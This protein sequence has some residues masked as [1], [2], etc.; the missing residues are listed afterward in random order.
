MSATFIQAGAQ[1]IAPVAGAYAT[2]KFLNK[3]KPK[4]P[5]PQEPPKKD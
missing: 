1:I 4:D 5:Q 3:D 2:V